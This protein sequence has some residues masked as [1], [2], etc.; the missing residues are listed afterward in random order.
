MGGSPIVTMRKSSGMGALGVDLA[1]VADEPAV[2]DDVG[3]DR[4]HDVERRA[5]HECL[6]RRNPAQVD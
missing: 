5:P 2:D 6:A 3:F 1:D 4:V